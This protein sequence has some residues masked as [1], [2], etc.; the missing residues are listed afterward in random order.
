MLF[1]FFTV[2][3]GLAVVES[4][5]E[6]LRTLRVGDKFT[7]RC[8]NP[9]N[10]YYNFD[11]YEVNNKRD[12]YSFWATSKNV[13]NSYGSALEN[14]DKNVIITVGKSTVRLSYRIQYRG[15]PYNTEIYWSTYDLILNIVNPYMTT[16]NMRRYKD[17]PP[18]SSVPTYYTCYV[19]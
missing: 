5:V 4:N 7:I 18:G 17:W 1:T 14:P 12:Q 8:K 9:N 15:G 6:I 10:I 19:L 2:S 3:V 13:L 11:T 16:N